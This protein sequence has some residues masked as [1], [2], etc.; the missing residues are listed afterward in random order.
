MMSSFRSDGVMYCIHLFHIATL[1][2]LLRRV[3]QGATIHMDQLMV[4]KGVEG[5]EW[6][7]GK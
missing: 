4:R 7:E 3:I 1:F 6:S 5:R 2:D